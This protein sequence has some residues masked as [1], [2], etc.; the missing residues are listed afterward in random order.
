VGMPST[1]PSGLHEAG[2]AAIVARM[3]VD[4]ARRAPALAVQLVGKL[5][6][7]D[8]SLPA[9]LV[10]AHGLLLLCVAATDGAAAPPLGAR[11]W[12]ILAAIVLGTGLAVAAPFYFTLRAPGPEGAAAHHPQ[13]RYLLPLAPAA[14]LLLRRARWEVDWE[15]RLTALGIWAAA[16]LTAGAVAVAWRYYS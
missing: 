5:G 8:V 11:R 4:Y 12:L 9:A 1:V 13:G 6:W 10:A 16:M 7:A 14:L 2:T 15:R 3:L